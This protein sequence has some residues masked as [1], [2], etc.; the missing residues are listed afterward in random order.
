[1]AREGAILAGAGQVRG[2]G[3]RALLARR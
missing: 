3:F 2:R 1:V